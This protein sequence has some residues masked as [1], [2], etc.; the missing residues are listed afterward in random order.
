MKHLFTMT[1][2][3]PGIDFV[4]EDTPVLLQGQ[5]FSDQ[6]KVFVEI[7]TLNKSED[8]ASKIGQYVH[9]RRWGTIT[10]NDGHYI[11]VTTEDHDDESNPSTETR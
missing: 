1:D 10:R 7:G 3:K 2:L 4:K 8:L 6:V 5:P 11:E 9:S